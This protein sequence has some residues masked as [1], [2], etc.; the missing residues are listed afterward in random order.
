MMIHSTAALL[1]LDKSE[2]FDNV[3]QMGKSETAV[4]HNFEQKGQPSPGGD[5][6]TNQNP[7]SMCGNRNS[8]QPSQVDNCETVRAPLYHPRPLCV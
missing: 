4:F 5:F 2:R 3:L 7:I 8:A 6:T 1:R